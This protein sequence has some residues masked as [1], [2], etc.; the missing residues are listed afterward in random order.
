MLD[1]K[2]IFLLIVVINFA[3]GIMIWIT[4]EIDSDSG[5]TMVSYANMAHGLG[6]LFFVFSPLHEIG[7]VWAGETLIALSIA[8]WMGAILTFLRVS[9]PRATPFILVG[10]VSLASFIYADDKDARIIFN[11]LAYIIIE[12]IVVIAML[13]RWQQVKGRGKYLVLFAV[14]VNMAVLFYREAFALFRSG[15]IRSLYEQ[16]ASQI[17]L[18]VS[19]LITLLFLSVG[20]II[21]AKERAEHI[22][23]DLILRDGLTGVW[24]RRKLD[25]VGV[26]EISRLQRHGTPVS[27]AIIDVDDFKRVND[28]Y[29][30]GVG[31]QVLQL[32]PAACSR[33]LRETDIIGRWGGEEFL[34]I[35]PNTGMSELHKIS[36][37]ICDAINRIDL[38]PDRMLSVSIGLSVCLS[39]DSFHSWFERADKALY[40]AKNTGKNRSS[41]DMPVAFD[42]DVPSVIW[43]DRF[44]S[45]IPD[46]DAEHFELIKLINVWISFS[47][48]NY[49]KQDL[50]DSI[51]NIRSAMAAHFDSEISQMESVHDTN[52]I[53]A[54]ESEHSRL[55]ERLDFLVSVFERGQLDLGAISE[56]LVCELFVDHIMTEDRLFLTAERIS[57][58]A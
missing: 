18:Y 41:F 31:D 42:A 22:N 27:L 33:V 30:H 57:S 39:K 34:V 48:V 7:F 1:V 28:V 3:L 24:N 14:V 47:R 49:S 15:P 8:G 56:F 51:Y 35:L 37:R 12:V 43:S 19:V 54:H 58:A 45:K 26:Y 13:N 50:L 10:C 11:S 46:I 5:L 55:I 21:M 20:F 52:E 32:I 40:H 53:N 29:G 38:L 17:T 16:D 4:S 23:M 25:E 36:S 44:E 9:L 2:T 6:Y